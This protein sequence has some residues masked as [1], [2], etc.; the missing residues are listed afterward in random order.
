MDDNDFIVV[1]KYIRS[2]EK[3][4]REKHRSEFGLIFE[5]PFVWSISVLDITVL[6]LRL[7]YF[8]QKEDDV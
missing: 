2:L 1:C 7:Q 8:E 3:T 5:L 4:V 6:V